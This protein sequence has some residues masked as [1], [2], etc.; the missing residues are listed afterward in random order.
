MTSLPPLGQDSHAG[1]RRDRFQSLGDLAKGPSLNPP[2]VQRMRQGRGRD[3]RPPGEIGPCQ[4]AQKH[5]MAE[6]IG[7][8][9]H[10]RS[11][12]LLARP[13]LRINKG[14][15]HM[16]EPT[17][18]AMIRLQNR[19][20]L[21]DLHLDLTDMTPEEFNRHAIRALE[22]AQRARGVKS[23]QAFARLLADRAGG[24][25][26]G[27]AYHRWLSGES[28]VPAWV[29]EVAAEVAAMDLA[30][31]FADDE[32]APPHDDWRL[33]TTQTLDRLSEAVGQLQAEMIANQ[34]SDPSERMD[35]LEDRLLTMLDLMK[36]LQSSVDLHGAVLE[37]LTNQPIAD[38]VPTPQSKAQP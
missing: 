37:N 13:V 4:A 21:S 3:A 30:A 1:Q 17:I 15:A 12:S 9:R 33:Q 26:S 31:L 6:F 11:S 22:R 36:R 24:T 23:N 8:H 29:L 10:T 14:I 34:R 16:Q 20:V 19:V 2:I 18:Y 7:I 25:P 32:P 5:L 35:G 38:A 28:I 27:S